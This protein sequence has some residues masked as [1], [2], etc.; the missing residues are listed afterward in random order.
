[1]SRDSKENT[2]RRVALLR[3]A[4]A[5]RPFAG[6]YSVGIILALATTALHVSVPLLIGHAIDS[7]IASGDMPGLFVVVAVILAIV[8]VRAILDYFRRYWLSRA[9]TRIQHRLRLELFEKLLYLPL[10]AHRRWDKGQLITRLKGDLTRI[11]QFLNVG[12]VVAL[13]SIAQIVLVFAVILARHWPLALVAAV[14][15]ALLAWALAVLLRRA[16]KASRAM[17]ETAGEMTTM[18]EEALQGI[19]TVWAFGYQSTLF[20]GFAQAAGRLRDIGVWRMRLSAALWT[21]MELIPSILLIVTVAVGGLAAAAGQLTVGD[22]VAFLALLTALAGPLDT[23]GFLADGAVK[24][25]VAARRLFE[26]LDEE[27]S[28]A[29][30]GRRLAEVRGRITLSDVVFQHADAERPLLDGFSL[31]IHPGETVA[32]VGANGSGKSSL[33]SLLPRLEDVTA[34]RIELDGVDVRE[35]QLDQVRS[36][37]GI[38]FDDPLLFSHTVRTNLTF[39]R[40]G[41]TD[42]ELREALRIARAEFVLDLPDGLE[43]RIGEQGLTLSGGQRQ[44]IALARAIVARPKVLVLDD[45]LS[46]LDI[47]TEREVEEALTSVLTSVTGLVISHRASTV[48]LA[49]RVVL[50]SEGRVGDVGTHAELLARSAEYRQLM[51]LD[52]QEAQP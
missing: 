25:E 29:P 21:V 39:G 49:H 40:S 17:S 44:R 31:D 32:F 37:F 5:L 10:A 14:V 22:V 3:L 30:G 20:A 6:V 1:M 8:I 9:S 43:T 11:R 33:V 7:P 26:V 15:T 50:I 46:A 23:L 38:A 27:A 2:K 18:V 16:A 12:L 24:A 52:A 51:C 41:A 47:H 4:P 13:S 42:E 36:T 19:R 45:T 48:Q 28:L 34:G 35:L